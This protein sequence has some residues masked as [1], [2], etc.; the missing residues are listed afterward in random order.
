[1]PTV[2][3]S[4]RKTWRLRKRVAVFVC[5]TALAIALDQISKALAQVTLADGQRHPLFGSLLGLRLLRNPGASLGLGSD[6]TWIISLIAILV[7]L[8]IIYLLFKTTSMLWTVVLS[9][10][11]SGAAGNLI[12]RVAYAQG[13]LDGSVVDFLDYGWS[14]GNIADIYLTVAALAVLILIL[15]DVKFTPS[16]GNGGESKIGGDKSGSSYDNGQGAAL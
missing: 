15:A 12:D 1:M 9:L 14:V 11:F 7:C 4:P 6:V 10:I 16:S 2:N 5:L 3:F 8:V 13:F